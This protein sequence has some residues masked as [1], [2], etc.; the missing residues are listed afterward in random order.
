MRGW[1]PFPVSGDKPVDEVT[2]AD[3][4]KALMRPEGA[5]AR[6]TGNAEL[7]RTTLGEVFQWALDEGSHRSNP[8]K[9]T[10]VRKLQRRK[11]GR[12]PAG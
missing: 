10:V 7:A 1:L 9:S 5:D 6:L 3:V 11:R 2:G 4:V 8:A 12:Y